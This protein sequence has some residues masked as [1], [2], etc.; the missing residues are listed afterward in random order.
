[1]S[2]VRTSPQKSAPAQAQWLEVKVFSPY[3]VFFEGRAYS[4]SAHNKVGVFDILYDHVNFFSLLEAG[5]VTVDAGAEPVVIPI[6][7]GFIKVTDN[8]AVLFVN[9]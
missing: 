6:T 4:L 1:M 8:T 5:D 7:R 2:K 3:Q 9:V